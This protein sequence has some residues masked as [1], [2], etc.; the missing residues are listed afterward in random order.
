M[1][2]KNKDDSVIVKEVH[3]PYCNTEQAILISKTEAKKISIQLPAYGLKY[4][5]SLLYLSILYMWI[6]GFKMIEAK[7]EVNNITYGFCPNCG[8][9][10]SMAPP[11]TVKE[12]MEEPKFYKIRDGIMGMCKGISEYTGISILWIRIMTVIYG[13]TVIGALLYFLIG[14]CVPFQDEMETGVSHKRF[15]R[16][17]KGKDIT[18]LCKGFSEYTGIP[19]MWV[20]LFTLLFGV[21]VLGTILYFLISAFIPVKENVEQG[22]V[23]K[24][25]YKI[26][27]KKVLF[28]L[29]VGIAEYTHMPLWLARVL[30]ILLFPLYILIAAIV[31]T[32]E[33]E[34]GK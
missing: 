9:G 5:L 12:E 11:E 28:G 7:K 2:A 17:N 26:R 22:I 32:M 6:Y 34:D 20:R 29:C 10:Y 25:L 33:D 13:L 21:T 16:V 4:V 8:N 23:K 15:Y 24:K 31:P 30:A 3:C 27:N 18:G 14:A 1:L 19:V